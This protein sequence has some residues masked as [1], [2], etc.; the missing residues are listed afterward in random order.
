[1]ING[2][3]I[4][5]LTDVLLLLLLVLIYLLDA[6]ES[7]PRYYVCQKYVA[8]FKKTDIWKYSNTHHLYMLSI[9]PNSNIVKC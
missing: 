5:R 6:S 2:K 7:G 4:E 1:V 8:S 9:L 3:R